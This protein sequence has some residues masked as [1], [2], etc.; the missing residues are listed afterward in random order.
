MIS[1][2]ILATLLSVQDPAN[3]ANGNGNL[4]PPTSLSHEVNALDVTEFTIPKE[5]QLSFVLE[6]ASLANPHDRPLGF[7]FPIIEI[8]V[9][10]DGQSG[11]S[12]ELLPG[13][14]M[15]LAKQDR[16]HY[17]VRLNG[18]KA[19]LFDASSGTASLSL[20]PVIVSKVNNQLVINTSL[21][22]PSKLTAY[23]LVGY[24]SPF[25]AT[26]WQALSQNASAWTY[27]STS[28]VLPVVD[29]IASGDSAQKQAIDRGVLPAIGSSTAPNYWIFVMLAGLLLAI[30]GLLMRFILPKEAVVQPVTV[31][32]EPN[33]AFEA[34][35]AMKST[36]KESARGSSGV[37][38]GRLQAATTK[39]PEEV[40]EAAEE[41]EETEVEED[42]SLYLAEP[43]PKK[44]GLSINIEDLE[45]LEES[46]VAE[47]LEPRKDSED[48]IKQK[49]SSSTAALP[50][51]KE[52]QQVPPKN[53]AFPQETAW[54]E[55]DDNETIWYSDESS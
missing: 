9:R 37:L 49:A 43:A 15:R 25:N 23:G 51:K 53:E 52:A 33:D 45:E 4:E 42:F 46:S 47:A 24:Y 27:S 54:L 19:E 40:T 28:Q 35:L 10:N 55:D 2:L 16:W 36:D 12:N 48:S 13:S 38:K 6:F 50:N 17:A 34:F 26:G 44:L 30:F 21:A 3:D 1:A 18:D 8:Y 29:L 39:P 7:S 5:G 22:R 41:A 11:G 31:K 32:P 20:Q 14:G